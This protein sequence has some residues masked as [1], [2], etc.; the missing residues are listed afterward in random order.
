MQPPSLALLCRRGCSPAP[1]AGAGADRHLPQQHGVD[2]PARARWSSSPAHAAPAAAPT[3]ALRVDGRQSDRRLLLPHAG[4][5]PRPRDRRDRAPAQRHPEGAAAQGL[6]GARP[7]RRRRR[8]VPARWSSRCSARRSCARSSPTAAEVPRDRARTCKRIDGLNKANELRLRA[9]NITSGPEKGSCRLLAF[10][11][12]KLVADVTDDGGRR[13]AAAAP[14]LLVGA[15]KNAKGAVGQLRRRR[16]PRPQPLLSRQSRIMRAMSTT[17]VER[18]RER[19]ARLGAGRQ[20]AGDRPQRQPQHLRPRRRRR[21]PGCCPASR[22]T[23]ATGSPTRSTTAA[24][25]SSGPARAS[26]PSTT[27]SSSTRAGL[28]MAPLERGLS[29]LAATRRR[30]GCARWAG[31]AGRGGR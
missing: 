23:R 20:L 12:G 28:T 16:R 5:R 21:W 18:P 15:P 30:P 8:Q 2:R 9:F 7:A 22:S 24:R 1:R 27:G 11:G 31:S 6:P 10:V 26:R 14:R 25:R 4:A 3:D 13:A 19:R 17:T 29:A